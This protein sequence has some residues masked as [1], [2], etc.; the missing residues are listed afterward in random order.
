MSASAAHLH[1][2]ALVTA[3]N[4]LGIPGGPQNGEGSVSIGVEG[5]QVVAIPQLDPVTGKPIPESSGAVGSPD[6]QLQDGGGLRRDTTLE[7]E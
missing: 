6:D 7:I 2:G 4:P 1:G 3:D 5:Q